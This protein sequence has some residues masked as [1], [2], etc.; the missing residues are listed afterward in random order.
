MFA[1]T[2]SLVHHANG[3]QIVESLRDYAA[4]MT[5]NTGFSWIGSQCFSGSGQIEGTPGAP[6]QN[7]EKKKSE[8]KGR[9][10]EELLPQ[11]HG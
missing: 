9:E 10:D 2:W 6:G 11:K 7:D 5:N 8:A 3:P 1:T 4:S